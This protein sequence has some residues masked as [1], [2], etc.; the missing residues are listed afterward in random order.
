MSG[1]RIILPIPKLLNL[2]GVRADANIIT[3]SAKNLSPLPDMR[4]AIRQAPLPVH[5]ERW[6]TCPGR[7]YRSP[8]TCV[9]EGSSAKRR[10][11]TGRS[12]RSVYPGRAAQL[13]PTNTKGFTNGSRTSPSPTWRGTLATDV[14][15]FAA[16][17]TPAI[18]N[19][20]L[21]ARFGSN[22][23]LDALRRQYLAREASVRLDKQLRIGIARIRH[24]DEPFE[25]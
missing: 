12:S 10:P 25:P 7:Q 24:H 16:N 22:T 19:A 4:Q 5:K 8:F 9:S 18:S 15:G 11:A 14:S 21:T 6:P 1:S 17:L 20:L 23:T 3:L 2:I 13:R